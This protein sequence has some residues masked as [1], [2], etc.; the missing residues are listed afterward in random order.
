[1]K[2]EKKE[3][4][5]HFLDGSIKLLFSLSLSFRG[6]VVYTPCEVDESGFFFSSL[7]IVYCSSL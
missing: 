4:V 2:K 1:M 6:R 7:F 3:T 5:I